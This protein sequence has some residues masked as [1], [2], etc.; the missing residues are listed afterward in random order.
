MHQEDM[1]AKANPSTLQRILHNSQTSHR[2]RGNHHQHY[3]YNVLSISPEAIEPSR[4][5][6]LTL[7]LFLDKI[8]HVTW[9]DFAK[10]FNIIIRMELCHFALRRWFSALSTNKTSISNLKTITPGERQKESVTASFT[11]K[12]L[13]PLVE[14]IVHYQGMAHAN[15]SRLHA[16]NDAGKKERAPEG[17]VIIIENWDIRVSGTIVEPSDIRVEEIALRV[18]KACVRTR[19]AEVRPKN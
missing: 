14:P 9:R 18:G 16:K 11:Y 17:T 10:E 3:L 4:E 13:H 5:N 2:T 12:Y 6:K 15:P 7:V 8:P 1:M 19:F